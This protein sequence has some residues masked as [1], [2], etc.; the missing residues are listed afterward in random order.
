MLAYNYA[1]ASTLKNDLQNR[2]HDLSAYSA[3]NA[4]L[5]KELQTQVHHLRFDY[6][7][8]EEDMKACKKSIQ[9]LES[10]NEWVDCN[11]TDENSDEEDFPY[12][13]PHVHKDKPNKYG[14]I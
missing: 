8:M 3:N 11:N 5:I 13:E 1:E 10:S 9:S 6:S 14:K 7:G 2:T 12:A 4:N